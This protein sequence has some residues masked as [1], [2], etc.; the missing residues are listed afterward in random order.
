MGKFDEKDCMILDLLQENCR[1]PLTKIAK[2]VGLSIDSVKK[3]MN[4]M[5]EN[6]VYHPQIQLRPRNFGFPNIVDVKIKVTYEDQKEL[7]GFTKYLRAH[8]R[9]SEIFA[10]VG[11]HDFSIV[12][13]AKDAID[14]GD[15]TSQIRNKFGRIISAWNTS[16]TTKCYKFEKYEMQELFAEGNVR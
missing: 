10:M 13:I 5:L 15:V 1:M 4:K 9:I 14:L 11:E 16:L 2:K 7:E 8:P 12:I 6:D 3:R